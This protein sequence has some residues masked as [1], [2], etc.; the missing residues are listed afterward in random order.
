MGTPYI[1]T[2]T[3]TSEGR[4]GHNALVRV[5]LGTVLRIVLR[6]GTPASLLPFFTNCPDTSKGEEYERAK[7]R[8]LERSNSPSAETILDWDINYEISCRKPGAYHFY[9]AR[10]L[11]SIFIF[12]QIT[13]IILYSYIS[14]WT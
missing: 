11:N 7:F 3:L 6:A 10:D 4:I 12:L 14:K 8:R 2:L 5:E 1:R 13:I 9:L